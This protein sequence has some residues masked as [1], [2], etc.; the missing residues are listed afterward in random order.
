FDG[1]DQRGRSDAVQASWLAQPLNFFA[2]LLRL[3]VDLYSR[4]EI[5]DQCGS[6]CARQVSL[7]TARLTGPLFCPLQTPQDDIVPAGQSEEHLIE[8][9]D[10][11]RRSPNLTGIALRP[12]YRGR[13][14]RNFFVA[15]SAMMSLSAVCS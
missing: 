1:A 5:L 15:R 3:K 14:L 12:P 7:L 13:A 8:H 11:H 2:A 4:V 9:A 10:S 6:D